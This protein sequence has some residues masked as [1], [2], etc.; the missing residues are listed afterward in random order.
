MK[1]RCTA[2]RKN[3][4]QCKNAAIKGGN[5]CRVHGGSAPQVKAAALRR[6][7]EAADPIAAEMIRLAQQAESETARIQAGRDL[8]DRAGL[9]PADKHE[10]SFTDD[11]IMAEIARLKAELGKA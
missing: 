7:Q 9:K 10:V 8:L 4:D 5:V 11:M 3:G 1:N 6:I 2:H